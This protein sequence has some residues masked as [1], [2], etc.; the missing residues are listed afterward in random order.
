MSGCHVRL[1]GEP[2]VHRRLLSSIAALATLCA[3][4]GASA[5]A[6][7]RKSTKT[8][9][10]AVTAPVDSPAVATPPSPGGFMVPKAVIL[11]PTTPAEAEANA[12]WN[13]RAALNVAALQCQY[14][15]YLATVKTYNAML[16]HHSEELSRAQATLV[17]HFK[18]YDG[19]KA[20]NSF[21]Q[22][23]T[24][25]YNSYSTLDAQYSFCEAAGRVGREVLATPRDKL[26]AEAIRRAPEIR[27]AFAEKPLAPA[28]TVIPMT[29]IA[30]GEIAS[31]DL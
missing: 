20:I 11:R 1:K 21:D 16:K 30:I 15:P 19:A 18:R 17:A 14:S 22:Y 27:E 7:A 31:P 23:T 24:R 6:T 13:I 9:K 3:L 26:G 25:T 28:L 4:S 12:V 2:V 5:A 8:T 29:A 10:P